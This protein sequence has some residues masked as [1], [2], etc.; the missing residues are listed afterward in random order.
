MFSPLGTCNQLEN[1]RD[2]LDAPEQMALQSS[3]QLS[4]VF[5]QQL[6]VLPFLTGLNPDAL[7]FN[8]LRAKIKK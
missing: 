5:Y 2:G 4:V 6:F 3:I 7:P 8:P 1:E